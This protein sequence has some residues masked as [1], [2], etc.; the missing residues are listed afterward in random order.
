M[1]CPDALHASVDGVDL[2]GTL[3]FG[4]PPAWTEAVTLPVTLT[5]SCPRRVRLLGHPDDWVTGD[6][7]SLGD[8]PAVY[9]DAGGS[10]TMDLVFTPG[11]EGAAS[12][13]LSLPHDGGD[14]ALT[15]ALSATVG[16]PLRVLFVGDGAHRLTTADYGATAAYD[17]WTTTEAHTAALL[18]GVCAGPGLFVA[19]GGNAERVTWTSPD[20]EAWEERVETG[21]PLGDCVW[22]GGQYVA[23]DGAPLVSLDGATWTRG[24]GSLDHHLRALTAG[25]DPDGGVTFVAVGD[26]GQIAVTRDGAAWDA[27]QVLPGGA[28]YSEVAWGGGVFVAAGSDG[29]TAASTD[30][31]VTWVEGSTGGSGAQGLV[32]ANGT[33]FLGDGASVYSSADG[34]AW[35]SVNAASAAPFAAV[36][37]RLLGVDG[38]T[39]YTSDDGG[40]TWEAG[41]SAAGGLGFLDAAVEV[42]E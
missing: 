37:S 12:G 9:V 17:A 10:T 23:F 1:L 19:V 4:T 16:S 31:G 40:F 2:A 21:S 25:E 14:G 42:R 13:E 26:D 36:G 39:I 30:G 38:G 15:L 22:A 27:E 24:S 11:A 8:L 32:Y 6:P 29:A 18:R 33:F 41:V 34:V 28:S 3:D 35:S 20:G 7:F 5:S